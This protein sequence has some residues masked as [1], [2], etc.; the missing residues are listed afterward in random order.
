MPS[1]FHDEEPPPALEPRD[2][3][4]AGVSTELPIVVLGEDEELV[5]DEAPRVRLLQGRVHP[6]WV[7]Y[8][9][10]ALEFVAGALAMNFALGTREWSAIPV[11]LAW[12]LLYVW[13]WFYGVAYRYRRRLLKYTS[14]TIIVMLTVA[15]AY[16]CFEKAGSQVAVLPSGVV[17]DREAAPG[18]YWA[19]VATIVAVG[20]LV[21]HIVF[22]GRGY[23]RKRPS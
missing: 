17:G 3:D 7:L 19:G 1:D 8:P 16:F 15:L 2:E 13:N 23:R 20:L 5:S 21:A 22:L 12:F 14:V 4:E 10:Y 11:G 18:L 9:I 6:A